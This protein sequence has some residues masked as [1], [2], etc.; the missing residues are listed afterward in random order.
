MGLGIITLLII[1]IVCSV[2]YLIKNR[3]RVNYLACIPFFLAT[4]ISVFMAA[5]NEITF[6]KNLLVKIDLPLRI[7]EIWSVFRASGRLVW[8]AVYFIVLFSIVIIIRTLKSNIIWP[9][10]LMCTILQLFDL[11]DIIVSK[12]MEFSRTEYDY[13]TVDEDFFDSITEER[14][15]EHIVFFDKDNLSQSD[16]FAFA[17]YAAE[18]NMTINDFYFARCLTH[19]IKEVAKDF[20]N[21]PDDSTIYVITSKSFAEKYKYDLVF[22]DYGDY[23]IGLK[24]PL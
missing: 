21:H 1:A 19:P 9:V 14:S 22:Y 15:I 10:L 13:S 17:K 8:P 23:A 18:H 7:T 16:L 12:H 3:F 6:G 20:F 5:S 4:L 24:T 2:I 11:Q